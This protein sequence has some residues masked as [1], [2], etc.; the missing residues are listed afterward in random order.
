VLEVRVVT[1]RGLAWQH[2]DKADKNRPK[3]FS[4]NVAAISLPNNRHCSNCAV[5]Q[6]ADSCLGVWRFGCLRRVES[7]RKFVHHRPTED[8]TLRGTCSGVLLVETLSNFSY[9]CAH[10]VFCPK[11][12]P[13]LS[14]LRD[15]TL[16]VHETASTL[17][18]ISIGL[19]Q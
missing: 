8:N 6:L 1:G 13:S 18:H 14:Q 19:D 7:E 11:I 9:L 2:S 5:W 16:R 3:V 10:E 17:S 12:S 15:N 4:T